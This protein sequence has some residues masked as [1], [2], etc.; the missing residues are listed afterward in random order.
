MQS[1]K[2]DVELEP[3]YEAQAASASTHSAGKSKGSG[4]ADR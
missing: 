1:Y 3:G 2:L 4:H